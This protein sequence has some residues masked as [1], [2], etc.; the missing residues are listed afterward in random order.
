MSNKAIGIVA[1]I[2]IIGWIIAFVIHKGKDD[3]SAMA[4]YHIEQSLG[5]IVVAIGLSIIGNILTAMISILGLLVLVLNLGIII[6]WVIGLLNA[7]N[8]KREPIPVI[9]EFF[10]GK[11][12]FINS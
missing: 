9:G 10:E 7:I 8:E 6:L 5:L 4:G 11:F 1:Y 12:G 2:T 3:K